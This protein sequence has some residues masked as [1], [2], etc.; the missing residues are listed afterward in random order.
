LD[1]SQLIK[2]LINI[3]ALP[4]LIGIAAPFSVLFFGTDFAG[5]HTP[6]AYRNFS[7]LVEFL[8]HIFP[9]TFAIFLTYKIKPK[10]ISLFYSFTTLLAMLILT[11]TFT[12]PSQN[13]N[14]V[15]NADF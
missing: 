13:V 1:D 14:F 9:I 2:G 8:I 6:E 11:L 15:Y 7:L 3:G 10:P 5:I 4:Q 12:S